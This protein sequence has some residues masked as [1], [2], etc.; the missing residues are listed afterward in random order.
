MTT[1]IEVSARCHDAEAM[2]QRLGELAAA[3]ACAAS[4]ATPPSSPPIATHNASAR[5]HVFRLRQGAAQ[6]A[7]AV[8]GPGRLIFYVRG[9]GA[10]A[11]QT[12]FVVSKTDAPA[13]LRECLALA[14]GVLGR[15]QKT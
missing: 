13:A 15:V 12:D 8:P 6:A 14:Y 2:R 10:G 5:R 9:D 4:S 3:A 1:L 7:R 11:K